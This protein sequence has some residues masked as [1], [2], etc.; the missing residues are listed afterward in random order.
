M[1]ITTKIISLCL[2]LL[3]MGAMSVTLYAEETTVTATAIASNSPIY[4]VVVPQEI[5]STEDLQRTETTSY[6]NEAFTVSVT[7]ALFL[8]GKQISVRVWGEDGTF[9]LK[10]ADGSSTLPYE[11]FSNTN[12]ESALQDGDVFATFTTVGSQ[13]G[14]V[15]IDQKNITKADIYT[16]NLRFSF[17]LSDIEE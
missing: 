10:N 17:S 16:G 13:S 6:H 14:F 8:D 5:T 7:E 9:V 15:R 2:V 1:K 12:A 4:T 11:V 3:L